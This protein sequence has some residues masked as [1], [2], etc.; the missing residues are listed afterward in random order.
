VELVSWRAQR[1][2]SDAVLAWRT[3]SETTSER[4]EIERK[5]EDESF[6][7]IATV[8]AQ[9]T[10]DELTD[11]QYRYENLRTEAEYTFRL[12]AVDTSGDVQMSQPVA[13]RGPMLPRIALFSPSPYW[14]RT[15]LR[16]EAGTM[17]TVRST[18]YTLDGTQLETVI[19]ATV[20]QGIHQVQWFSQNQPDGLYELRIRIRTGGKHGTRDT[21][22]A[23][24]VQN[25]TTTATLGTTGEDG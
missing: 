15:T 11:Y 5:I 4:F 25:P 20:A 6:K 12:P 22:Y 3:A 17:S 16:A 18:V 13:L 24:V 8:E 9:G 1:D 21:T 2:G 10:T 19:N 7:Q 14:D 23:V